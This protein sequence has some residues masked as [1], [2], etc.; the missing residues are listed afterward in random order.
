MVTKSV[1]RG[2]S[3]L[4]TLVLLVCV[5]TWH[6]MASAQPE[7]RAAEQN[8]PDRPITIVVGD[9]AGGSSDASARALAQ[10][11]RKYLNNVPINVENRPGGTGVVGAQYALSRPDDGLTLFHN[12]GNVH[13]T[14]GRHIRTMPFN[15]IEAF[16]GV[17]GVVSLSIGMSVPMNSPFRNVRELVDHAKRNPDQLTFTT[18]GRGGAHWLVAIDF[19]RKAGIQV[20]EI[21]NEQGGA[22]ARNLVAGGHV[23]ISFMA[24]FLG[25]VLEG[26]RLRT[27]AV[28]FPER[29]P[30]SPQVPTFAESGYDVVMAF[31]TQIL[32]THA[33]V[34][35]WKVR[36]L[37][38]AF[39]QAMNDPEFVDT[40]AK[41]GLVPLPWDYKKAQQH[42]IDMDREFGVLA[43]DLGL[44]Q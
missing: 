3:L 20:R 42:A 33:S 19:M 34:P 32:A 28:A 21:S 10:A 43:R 23:D 37:S 2:K 8:W 16:Q 12:W 18:A 15:P 25:A 13:W 17:A 14:F 29:D 22:E 5:G 44:A 6:I 24:T 31:P 26:D 36:R 9:N 38:D 4:I 27:L 35:E 11:A 41:L 40:V 1:G 30:L 39:M 7:V